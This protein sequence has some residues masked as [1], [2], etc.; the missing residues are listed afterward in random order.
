MTHENGHTE[1]SEFTCPVDL[2]NKTKIN[3]AQQ[4]GS[5]NSYA[6]RYALSNALNLSFG[7]EDDDGTAAAAQY[8]T[9]DQA[10][11]IR[12]LVEEK[13]VDVQLFLKW[14]GADSFE[15]VPANKYDR[16]VKEYS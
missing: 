8:V 6:K 11:H 7:G 16:I 4:Q 15:T 12:D 2:E 13:M 5:A 9:P 1:M 10:T 14:A 3:V